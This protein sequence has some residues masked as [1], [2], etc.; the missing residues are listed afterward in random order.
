MKTNRKNLETYEKIVSN[1]FDKPEKVFDLLS[2][3][4]QL[5]DNQFQENHL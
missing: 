5:Q 3:K 1:N 4:D 2:K